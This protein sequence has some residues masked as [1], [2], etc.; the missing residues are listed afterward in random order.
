MVSFRYS[1]ENDNDHRQYNT[2][3]KKTC[4]PLIVGSR[5]AYL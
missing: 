2:R 3:T 5:Q 1:I 4:R